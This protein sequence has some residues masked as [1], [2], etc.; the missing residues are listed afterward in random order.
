[1]NL[2]PPPEKL[3]RSQSTTRYAIGRLQQ[4]LGARLFSIHG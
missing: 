2:N 4:Q 1:V 3:N